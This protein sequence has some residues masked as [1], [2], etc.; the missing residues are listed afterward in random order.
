MEPLPDQ[1]L[2]DGWVFIEHPEVGVSTNPVHRS[3]LPAWGRSGWSE[4]VPEVP[5]VAAPVANPPRVPP[6]PTAEQASP[7][8]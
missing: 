7:Q 2:P 3:S 8:Q 4:V 6:V 1:P 5:P